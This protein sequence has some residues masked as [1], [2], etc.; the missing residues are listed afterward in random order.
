MDEKD[1]E[2][3]F[4]VDGHV[5]SWNAS[6]ENQA[7][8][9]GT[10]FINCFH[11]Y[12]RNRSPEEWVWPL[13]KFQRYGEETLMQDLFEVGYDDVAIFLPT[14]LTDFYKNG[15]NTTEQDAVL[16]EKHPE[17]FILNTSFARATVSAGCRCS[18]RRCAAG[19]SRASSS[20][21]PNGAVT[22]AAGS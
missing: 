15:F 7:N 2:R 20:T 8:E 22:R 5:H 16:K 19:T 21:P 4:I 1:V 9:F 11:D 10:G 3:Y 6:P 14:Y 18:R 13:E 12:H 17:R